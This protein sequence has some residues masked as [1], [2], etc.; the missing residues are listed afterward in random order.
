MAIQAAEIRA[1]VVANTNQAV[2]NLN[3]V[4]S[5]IQRME[6]A[7]G[8]GLDYVITVDTDNA[9]AA[10]DSLFQGDNQSEPPTITPQ[11]DEAASIQQMVALLTELRDLAAANQPKVEPDVDTKKP[12]DALKEFLKYALDTST[13]IANSFNEISA[14]LSTAIAPIQGVV[15]AGLEAHNSYT[16]LSQS[17]EALTARELL[18][19]GT[20]TEMSEALA[21]AAP[22]AKELLDWN[23]ELALNSPFSEEGVAEAFKMAQAFG[24]VTESANENVISAKRLTEA[25]I[26][27]TV[28]TGN[29]EEM[30]SRLQLA[31]GQI[32]AKGKLAGDEVLQLVEAGVNVDKILA[33]AFG[34]SRE[35]IVQMREKG[36][37]PANDAILAIVKSMEHDYSGAAERMSNTMAGV[38]N[39]MDDIQKVTLR[40][41][42]EGTFTAIT[43]ILQEFI[44]TL[45]DPE[46]LEKIGEWGDKLGEGV[47]VVLPMLIDGAMKTA[48]ALGTLYSAG[49]S[50]VDLLGDKAGPIFT[51]LVVSIGAYTTA[52]AAANVQTALLAATSQTQLIPALA[53]LATSVGTSAAAVAIA[54]APYIAFAAA[55]AGVTWAINDL[56]KKID[57]GVAKAANHS[58]GYRDSS[59]VLAE[60]EQASVRTKEALQGNIDA[61]K[62]NREAFEQQIENVGRLGLI[63]GENS[64]KFQEAY[65]KMINMSKQLE[66]DSELIRGQIADFEAHNRAVSES[67]QAIE[68]QTNAQKGLG[69]SLSLTGEALR[70]YNEQIKE[71]NAEGAE[72]WRSLQDL[73][74]EEDAAAEERAA[75]HEAKL[76]AIQEAAAENAEEQLAKHLDKLAEIEDSGQEKREAINEQFAEAIQA[77]QKKYQEGMEEA[78]TQHAD[79]L[80]E[81]EEK[82]ASNREKAAEALAKKLQE[83]AASHQQAQLDAEANYQQKLLDIT[84]QANE[85]RADL[86]ERSA[87]KIADL[88]RQIA[89][90]NDD[91]ARAAIKKK[92]DAENE[93]YAERLAN[94]EDSKEARIASEEKEFEKRLANLEKNTQKSLEKERQ[95]YADRLIALQNSLENLKATEEQ[96]YETRLANQEAKTAAALAK[97]EEL[98]QTNQERLNSILYQGQKQISD[99]TEDHED[100]LANIRENG[101]DKQLALDLEHAE[102]IAALEKE[103][104][105][106]R[107]YWQQQAIFEEIELLNQAYAKESQAIA[108]AVA[109]QEAAE[110]AAYEKRKGRME[111]DLQERLDAEQAAAEKRLAQA[112]ANL[113]NEQAIYERLAAEHKAKLLAID[114][115]YQLAL[116]ELQEA[117]AA[118]N[119]Q[120]LANQAE[121]IEALT[122]EHKERLLKYEDAWRE[123]VLQAE[124]AHQKKLTALNEEMNEDRLSKQIEALQAKIEAERASYEASLI[125][126]DEN[127]AKQIEKAQIAL[128]KKSADLDKA[129]ERDTAKQRA[130]YQERLLDIDESL[131]EAQEKENASYEKRQA[132]LQ[133]ALD[134]AIE[135]ANTSY[136]KRLDELDKTLA[137]QRSKEEA[138]YLQQQASLQK[139]LDEKL[140]AEQLAYEK[141]QQRADEYYAERE[142]AQLKHLGQM[143]DD[144]L[145][146]QQQRYPHLVES[147]EKERKK[148]QEEYGLIDHE[149][150]R[151]W[152]NIAEYTLRATGAI[153]PQMEAQTAKIRDLHDRLLEQRDA[154]F[155]AIDATQTYNSK[156]E[157]SKQALDFWTGASKPYIVQLDDMNNR[158]GTT[159]SRLQGTTTGTRTWIDAL[160]D[161]PSWLFGV[162]SG[163]NNSIEGRASGGPVKAGKVY[164][165]NETGQEYFMP[166]QD[167]TILPAGSLVPSSTAAAYGGNNGSRSEPITIQIYPQAMFTTERDLIEFIRE[168]LKERGRVNGYEVQV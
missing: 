3:E 150:N 20:V 33:D 125:D 61:L 32:Q 46:N 87:A 35:E 22:K 165:I 163:S 79:R 69:M 114:E 135:T 158:L 1:D 88:E 113:E 161:F 77:A 122:A 117:H 85:K 27:Y 50:V 74:A 82:A 104:R 137:K 31:L 116:E 16:M 24:F 112:Q 34:K 44:D 30:M 107:F 130:A 36:L 18:H 53:T 17:L 9:K 93:S 42:F 65:D 142:Q 144:Y 109:K 21:L 111:R 127:V 103:A 131:A 13:E 90:L 15:A 139:S 56:N 134:K 55:V 62:H 148:I 155:K 154:N 38:M 156:L 89:G 138:A 160:L 4:W 37:I 14:A 58:E 164:E 11:V 60:F 168:G 120:I 19:A 72:S 128:D 26:D 108:D 83:L 70:Q 68:G 29:S 94:L 54:A 40:E 71:I 132:D 126:L 45:S 59:A 96:N 121:N 140:L 25:L 99:Y 91:E 157:D 149:A 5:I 101:N 10:L 159:E 147:I 43:P 146:A 80:L 124:S 162:G 152:A 136:T 23:R 28:A 167:G 8:S 12:K 119:A 66:A 123:S 52:T 75:E 64:P 151:A 51:G 2:A 92:I 6:N 81:L 97:L 57:E 95:S 48:E 86:A 133:S 47:A 49:S 129:L 39:A 102:A 115:D 41:F 105:Q 73:Y 106:A 141:A 143:L 84:E 76:L 100:R 98:Y 63:Y 67:T 7:A 153:T 166:Y 78:A 110:I 145:A 118:N